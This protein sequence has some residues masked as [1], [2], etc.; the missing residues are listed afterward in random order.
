MIR[1]DVER[2]DEL[3]DAIAEATRGLEARRI[4]ELG[5]GTGETSRRVL[6][7]HPEASL[8]GIDES[9]PMLVQA[10]RLLPR[11][12]LR[13]SRLQDPLPEG[14]FDLVVS[15]LT[16]HHL[17]RDEKAD[18]FQRVA[19]VLRPGG[20]FVMGDVVVPERETDAVTP[21][22]EGFDLPDSVAEQLDWL[23]EAGLAARVTWSWKDLAVIAADAQ[24]S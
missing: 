5:T 15:A 11:A 13:T 1:A 2:F 4:L 7:D 9:E 8:T 24:E 23:A 19:T 21:L 16:V 17:G 22:T 20:R 3:Q 6:E 12:D 18:L 10:R 14:P